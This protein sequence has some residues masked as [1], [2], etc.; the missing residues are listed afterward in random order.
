M[1]IMALVTTIMTGPALDGINFFFRRKIKTSPVEVR[2]IKKYKILVAF[3][4]QETG[5]KLLGLANSFVKKLNNDASVT[6]MQLSPSNELHHYNAE[7]YEQECFVPITEESARLNQ[8]ITAVF[9]ASN[10]INTD[11]TDAANKGEYDLLLV[12]LGESIFEET[13]LG[14]VLGFTTRIVNPDRLIDKFTGREKLFESSPF[15]ETTRQ[16]IFKSKVPVG[17]LIDKN[18]VQT[19][20]VFIPLFN[21]EDAFLIEYAQKLMKNSDATI[22]ILDVL[23]LVKDSAGITD[24]IAVIQKATPD[25]ISF[26]N[27]RRIGKEFLEQQDIMIISLE[28]WKKLISSQSI[29]LNNTPSVLILKP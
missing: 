22:R 14:K 10:D 26:L 19:K 23:G 13:L 17:I 1:V 6:T 5:K 29:W 16:I 20:Q 4:S 24:S 25:R 27:E 11:I 12:S 8:K 2:S 28:S 9:K 3:E 21:E 18:L 15:D 7:E